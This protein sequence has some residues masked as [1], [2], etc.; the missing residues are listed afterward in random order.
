MTKTIVFTGGGTAGHIVPNFSLIEAIQKKG[1]KAFYIGSTSGLE[2]NLIKPLAV[3]FKGVSSGKL[4]RYFSWQNFIDPFKIILGCI[5]AYYYL[6]K[7]K[8]SLIFSKGGFVAFPVVIAAWLK[9]IPVIAHESDLTPG[10]A[11]RLSFPFAKIICLTFKEGARYFKNDSKLVI[12]GTPIR[13]SLLQGNKERAM[14]L[15]QFQQEKP[16]LLVIGG[17]QGA[18]HINQVVRDALPELIKSY[19]IIHLCGQGK[20]DSSLKSNPGYAQFEYLGQE[21]ADCY[22]LSTIVLSRSG[23]NS[24]YEILTLNKPHVFVP[25]PLK[26][27]R[28]D[29]IH[30]ARY[31]E[32]LGVSYVIMEE[33][34]NKASLLSAL[35]ELHLCQDKV[36]EKIA[37]LNIQSGTKKIIDLI[38][39]TAK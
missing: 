25:L 38:L 36:K 15:C 17:G 6:G 22:A 13:E 32:R 19:N 9:G 39:R 30:N 5:Q 1:F 21:L 4:R 14:G 20:I 33:A 16:C 2:E 23:A 34:L 26:A 29:Q 7:I 12:T 11:N 8:P 37:A 24:V 31:F 10:L 28:G 18:S 27:S 35:E 3:P